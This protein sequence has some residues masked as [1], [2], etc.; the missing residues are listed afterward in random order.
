MLGED[1]RQAPQLSSCSFFSW[2][3]SR[4]LADGSFS[5]CLRWEANTLSLQNGGR[6]SS[7]AGQSVVAILAIGLVDQCGKSDVA[8]LSRNANVI[9]A[10]LR[11]HHADI[12]QHRPNQ[13]LILVFAEL[14]QHKNGVLPIVRLTDSIAE[15][16]DV[17]GVDSFAQIV[18]QRKAQS[19]CHQAR[20][21]NSC[22]PALRP[23]VANCCD[24]YRLASPDRNRCFDSKASSNTPDYSNRRHHAPQRTSGQQC[25]RWRSAF[26]AVTNEERSTTAGEHSAG[27]SR[28][29]LED[30]IQEDPLGFEHLHIQRSGF[31]P[32]A[33]QRLVF[34]PS[35]QFVGRLDIQTGNESAD[36]SLTFKVSNGSQNLT[37]SKTDLWVSVFG[38]LSNC[39]ERR[40][41]DFGQGLGGHLTLDE[42]RVSEL[43]N[44]LI[45]RRFRRT[46]IGPN[47]RPVPTI[48]A[49][50][51]RLRSD[52]KTIIRASFQGQIPLHSR[53]DRDE[54]SRIGAPSGVIEIADERLGIE[55]KTSKHRALNST[56]FPSL[57]ELF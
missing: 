20:P 38:S 18:L 35:W 15:S 3:A 56:C 43:F 8:N 39:V 27:Q 57:Q 14:G 4:H 41:T 2:F 53:T 24:N 34:H 51:Q 45:R 19:L 36:Q 28:V 52:A 42:P 31:L 44:Q 30:S 11:C 23:A 29:V 6:T 12:V 33:D 17:L 1:V 50:R 5:R 54:T 22:Q 26:E 9:D 10:A 46:V 37:R 16:H 13:Q 49:T 32:I 21:S 40:Q 47:M 25:C 55:R 7:H 48:N